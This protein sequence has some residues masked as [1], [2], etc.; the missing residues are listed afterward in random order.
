MKIQS[1]RKKKIGAVLG[2]AALTMSLGVPAFAAEEGSN[3]QDTSAEST[4]VQDGVSS[5]LTVPFDGVVILDNEI[6]QV[7]LTQFFQ[8]EVNWADEGKQIEKN[9]TLKVFNKSDSD[10][11]FNVQDGYVHDESVSIVMHDGNSG[12]QPGKSKTLSYNVRYNTSPN[13]T[14]LESIDDL[15]DFECEIETISFNEDRSELV[16]G[17]NVVTNIAFENFVS[18]ASVSQSGAPA[19]SAAQESSSDEESNEAA[20]SKDPA[21]KASKISLTEADLTKVMIIDDLS[22]LYPDSYQLSLN[23]NDM[24]QITSPDQNVVMLVGAREN[25][26]QIASYDELKK[27]AEGLIPENAKDIV[28]E[29]TTINKASVDRITYMVGAE[30]EE[31]A[32]A[33]QCVVNCIYTEDI[34]YIVIIIAQGEG[35]EKAITTLENALAVGSGADNKVFAKNME[36][37]AL[38]DKKV[39]A[40]SSLATNILNKEGVVIFKNPELMEPLDQAHA[41]LSAYVEEWDAQVAAAHASEPYTEE[42]MK[43]FSKAS[44]E[45]HA[46]AKSKRST[47]DDVNAAKAAYD[48]AWYGLTKDETTDSAT[49]EVIDAALQGTWGLNDGEFTFNAGAIVVSGQGVTMDGSYEINT[50]ESAIK[51]HFVATDGN[52]SVTFPYEYKDGELVIYN[53]RGEALV[54]E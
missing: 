6:V 46:V 35:A 1:S 3:V 47:G 12:P 29:D 49:S 23:K 22:F 45:A 38:K 31:Q 44:D 26:G 18:P 24:L 20:Q 37:F 54:K 39:D 21:R 52:V 30:N 41:D 33:D 14:P 16:G 15:Y 25:A 51:G 8:E 27:L 40:L 10:I 50:S 28:S 2:A 19:D 7:E 11:I 42:S 34:S 4:A 17:S 13:E 32:Q 53:N 9:F 48:D 5:D 36:N 43:A